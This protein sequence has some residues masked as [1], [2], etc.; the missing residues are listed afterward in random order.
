MPKYRVTGFMT[1]SVSVVVE[2]DSPAKAREAARDAPLQTFC[3]QCARGSDD[4]WSTTGDL[5][6]MVAIRRDGV[7]EA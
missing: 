2:A 7:E 3:N 1:I 5:D 6:G 4:E